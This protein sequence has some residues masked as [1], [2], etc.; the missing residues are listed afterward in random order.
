MNEDNLFTLQE[1]AFIVRRNLR[2]QGFN[3]RDEPDCG[4]H[5]CRRQP[6]PG[7]GFCKNHLLNY[8]S[9]L[10]KPEDYKKYHIRKPRLR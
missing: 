1:K 7:Y 10:I 3:R 4:Q 9:E 6:E 8:F 5:Q 2:L